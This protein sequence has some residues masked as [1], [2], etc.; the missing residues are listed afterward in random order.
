MRLL[1]FNHHSS[2]NLNTIDEVNNYFLDLSKGIKKY[3]KE[4]KNT[5]NRFFTELE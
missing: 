3:T 2:N 5:Q 1:I 4:M